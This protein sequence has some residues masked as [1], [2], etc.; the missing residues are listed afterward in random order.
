MKPSQIML[1]EESVHAIRAGFNERLLALRDL[2]KRI[3]GNIG[4]RAGS[5]RL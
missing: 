2:K 1:L 3:L 4:A 5:K